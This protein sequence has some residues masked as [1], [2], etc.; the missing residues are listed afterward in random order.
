MFNH[1][2]NA[3][4]IGAFSFFCWTHCLHE[5]TYRGWCSTG[6][7]GWEPL[8]RTQFIDQPKQSVSLHAQGTGCSFS[9]MNER[10]VPVS[11]LPL[12]EAAKDTAVCPKSKPHWTQW[13][14]RRGFWDTYA[15]RW[16]VPPSALSAHPWVRPSVVR[17]H[18]AS[19]HWLTAASHG[20]ASKDRCSC[21]S[22]LYP[23]VPRNTVGNQQ[24]SGMPL[25]P[26]LKNSLPE[27]VS[28]LYTSGER[29]QRRPL[30]EDTWPRLKKGRNCPE[31]LG[32]LET[33]PLSTQEQTRITISLVGASQGLPLNCFGSI[34]D[35]SSGRGLTCQFTGL[36][37]KEEAKAL[38]ICSNM[39]TRSAVRRTQQD[40]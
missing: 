22:S 9:G 17:H 18:V 6:L 28:F 35:P 15:K 23:S 14:S 29:R 7:G 16:R 10:Q 12:M 21:C 31:N 13:F 8:S 11:H 20:G 40:K 2:D 39:A 32:C 26:T 24:L 25:P 19:V 1:S 38:Y 30:Q 33:P 5:E 27:S 3:A 36:L 34:P 4:G 37:F